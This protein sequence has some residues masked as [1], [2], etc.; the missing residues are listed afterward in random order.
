MLSPFFCSKFKNQL[1][2]LNFEQ[3][4]GNQSLA[5]QTGQDNT[6]QGHS[7]VLRFIVCLIDFTILCF[8]EWENLSD[9][10]R[11]ILCV[12]P[13]EISVSDPSVAVEPTNAVMKSRSIRVDQIIFTFV[14]IQ[15]RSYPLLF[16]SLKIGF[17]LNRDNWDSLN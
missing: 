4:E 2:N 16:T 14:D 7:I 12:N 5:T 3:T 11:E 8:R 15:R 17:E 6:F 13:A 1:L 10:V 9:E